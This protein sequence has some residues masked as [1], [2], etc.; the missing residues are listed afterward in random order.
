MKK[1][2]LSGVLICSISLAGGCMTFGEGI[3]WTYTEENMEKT[4]TGKWENCRSG[5]QLFLPTEGWEE[6]DPGSELTEETEQDALGTETEAETGDETE[7]ETTSSAETEAEAASA[8]TEIETTTEID[9]YALRQSEDGITLRLYHIESEDESYPSID[10]IFEMFGNSSNEYLVECNNIKAIH[11]DSENTEN[12]A[13]PEIVGDKD[14]GFIGSVAVISVGCKDREDRELFADE[15]FSSVKLI[16]DNPTVYLNNGLICSN[17]FALWQVQE[18]SEEY[19]RMLSHKKFVSNEEEDEPRLATGFA[20]MDLDGDGIMELLVQ[21]DGRNPEI[22][23]VDQA[24]DYAIYAFSNGEKKLLQT[25]E[26]LGEDDT[27]LYYPGL[28]IIEYDTYSYEDDDYAFH[29]DCY[30]YD[31]NKIS[32]SDYYSLGLD[33]KE[34]E[35]ILNGIDFIIPNT[36]ENQQTIAER[37]QETMTEYM[38]EN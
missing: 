11:F 21:Y 14:S 1:I 3:A 19:V 13:L 33:Q 17:E 4:Y 20:L 24:T 16:S 12:L 26:G 29:Y 31:G 38:G 18:A 23:T 10:D 25:M 9:E 36:E 8:E 7:A 37:M 5:F 35:L 2:L 30:Q 15:L 28:K 34:D 22:E 6:Y 27:L 32:H